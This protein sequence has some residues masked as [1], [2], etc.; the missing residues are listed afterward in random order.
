MAANWSINEPGGHHNTI[1]EAF[2]DQDY[3]QSP[4]YSI[5]LDPYEKHTGHLLLGAINT[6]RYLYPLTEL[7][8]G[9][10]EAKAVSQFVNFSL[11]PFSLDIFWTRT[12]HWLPTFFEALID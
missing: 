2:V 10:Y 9:L 11:L 5:W 12:R 6:K 7:D 4:A 3:I 8:T 1:L